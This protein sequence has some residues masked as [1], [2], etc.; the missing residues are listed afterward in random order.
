MYD[1][2]DLVEADVVEALEA[3]T[4]DRPHAM[5]GNKEVLLPPHEYV[6]F[7]QVLLNCE[8]ALLGLLCVRPE[9]GKLGPV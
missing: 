1:T 5:V 4:V 7:L 3:G 9:R 6:F 2:L 8:V